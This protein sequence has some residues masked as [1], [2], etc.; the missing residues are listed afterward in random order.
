MARQLKT[1]KGIRGEKL[2]IN[3]G[4]VFTGTLTA[5]MTQSKDGKKG[6]TYRSFAID[7]DKKGIT[8]SQDKMKDF[9]DGSGDIVE[10]IKGTWYF[11]VKEIPDGGNADDI[12]V[13]LQ[14]KILIVND[15]TGGHTIV[16]AVEAY[17]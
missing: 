2:R 15:R 7:V 17:T 9:V 8:M 13:V 6:D 14:G 1:V 10:L 4:K 3:L 12:K 5:W 16:Q 11:D